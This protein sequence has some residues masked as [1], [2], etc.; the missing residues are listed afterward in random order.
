MAEYIRLHSIK[1]VVGRTR[2][3]RSTLYQEMKS[4]RLQSVKVGS[5]RLVTESA[6]I[7]YIRNLITE[8]FNNEVG[9]QP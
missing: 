2:L 3:S 9:V 8:P 1:D 4:G 6:L 5:R 7:D